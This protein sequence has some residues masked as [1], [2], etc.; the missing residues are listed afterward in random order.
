ML[1]VRDGTVDSSLDAVDWSA[2]DNAISIQHAGGSV[3][4]HHL[5]E[6]S[7][8][9]QPGQ[10]V[11]AGQPLAKVGNS[12]ASNAPHL[13]LVAHTQ[14]G[15]VTPIALDAV[16]VGLNADP[17]DPWAQDLPRWEPRD[18]FFVHRTEP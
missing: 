2:P 5:L 9:V 4:L 11:N 18:G 10:A 14:L 17:S 12:G 7:L 8:I 16:T 1:T 15:Q 13:H 3:S 6:G